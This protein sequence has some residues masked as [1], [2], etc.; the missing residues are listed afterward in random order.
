MLTLPASFGGLSYQPDPGFAGDD[1]F[2]YH[3]KDNV[4]D[5]ADATASVTVTNSAPICDTSFYGDQQT[6]RTGKPCR[7]FS[8]TLYCN[9][10]SG[11]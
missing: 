10:R 9:I 5:G 2:S 3:A 6:L 11:R 1:H 7:T 8:R 4:E